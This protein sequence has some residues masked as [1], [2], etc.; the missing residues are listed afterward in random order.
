LISKD[1]ST[2]E[3]DLIVPPNLSG[4]RSL[5]LWFTPM[6]AKSSSSSASPRACHERA[7]GSATSQP[8]RTSSPA[9]HRWLEGRLVVFLLSTSALQ[10]GNLF[11]VTTRPPAHL[12]LHHLDPHRYSH[13]PRTPSSRTPS[14]VPAA[15]RASLSELSSAAATFSFTSLP[16]LD[17]AYPISDVEL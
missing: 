4:T 10:V 7:T 14:A 11:V 5:S 15:P 8:T 6:P 2:E 3:Y 9:C 1:V 16:H 17:S 12:H 13:H